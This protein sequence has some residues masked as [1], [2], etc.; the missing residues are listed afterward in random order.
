[1]IYYSG[2]CCSVSTEQSYCLVWKREVF[3][4]FC[5]FQFLLPLGGTVYLA[6]LLYISICSAYCRYSQGCTVG[7]VSEV[8]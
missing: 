7:L 4:G 2:L 5:A 6:F 1:M 8:Q 3:M